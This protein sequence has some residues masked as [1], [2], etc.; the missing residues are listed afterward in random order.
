MFARAFDAEIYRFLRNRTGWFWGM[1]FLPLIMIL[2]GFGLDLVSMRTTGLTGSI[3][4]LD[5]AIRTVAIGGNPVAHLFYALGA[6][7]LFADDYRYESWRL[8]AYRS[9]RSS[10]I[11]ARLATFLLFA[12]SSLLFASVASFAASELVL[13]VRGL[14][15][16]FPGSVDLLV[17]CATFAG[18]LCELAAYGGIAALLCIATRSLMAAVLAIFFLSAAQ[19]MLEAYLNI[20]PST[21]WP[22]ILPAF[23]GDAIRSWAHGLPTARA[24]LEPVATPET[25]LVAFGSL[26]GWASFFTIA[27]TLLFKQ[28]DLSRE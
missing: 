24:P 10:L 11:A 1:S 7:V 3:T 2:F 27:A 18:S 28:Q 26:I 9:S 23:S 13:A 15:L 4:P 16:R 19:S 22:L 12:G 20:A 5:H 6:A 8:I 21:G 25:A 14:P 17:W